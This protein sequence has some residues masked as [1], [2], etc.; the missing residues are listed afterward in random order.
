MLCSYKFLMKVIFKTFEDHMIFRKLKFQ[1]A[2]SQKSLASL[3]SIFK[4]II[5]KMSYIL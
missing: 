4:N 3:L 5:F 2:H 1:K